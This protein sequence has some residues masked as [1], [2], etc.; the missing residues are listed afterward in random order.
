MVRQSKVACRNHDVVAT[1][2]VGSRGNQVQTTLL[3]ESSIESG[4]YLAGKSCIDA[5]LVILITSVPV[6]SPSA[7]ALDVLLEIEIE[8]VALADRGGSGRSNRFQS[9]TESGAEAEARTSS[10]STHV[11]VIAVSNTLARNALRGASTTLC[12]GASAYCRSGQ[13][14]PLLRVESLEHPWVGRAQTRAKSR[15]VD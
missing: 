9:G 11:R 13:T 6:A 5:F 4:S 8:T 7:L 2:A 14:W 10:L 15:A 12:T 3:A 1:F